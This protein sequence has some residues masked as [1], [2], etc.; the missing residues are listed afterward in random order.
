MILPVNLA[1]AMFSEV[2]TAFD[3]SSTLTDHEWIKTD[4]TD[5]K[6]F[7]KI[8][9]A[10]DKDL[11]ILAEG[12]L[13]TGAIVIHSFKKELYYHDFQDPDSQAAQSFIHFQGKIWRVK[14]ESNRSNDGG[15]RR[16]GAVKFQDTRSE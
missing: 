11:D 2:I 3:R 13:V 5:Y 6:F 12:D 4:G 8:S 9:S 10:T 1:I 14:Q 16:Y 7:G 15:Y